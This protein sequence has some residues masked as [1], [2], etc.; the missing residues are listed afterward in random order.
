MAS[1]E[2][3]VL[4]REALVD[5]AVAAPST[6]AL[7]LLYGP[8]PALRFL[9]GLAAALLAQGL[10]LRA[11]RRRIGPERST[12]ADTLTLLRATVGAALAGLVVSGIHDRAGLAGWAAWLAAL[13]AATFCDWLDGP[14]ARRLG[15]TKLGGAL[16]IEADSWL[17]L[18]CAAGA[19]AWGGLPWWVVAPPLA[20]YT[21]PALALARGGLP[22]GGDPW[23]G[24]VTG[25]AQ[26]LLLLTALAPIQ[27]Y[28]RDAALSLAALPIAAGQ[29]ASVLAMIAA[30]L[31]ARDVAG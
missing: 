15:P 13:L 26:V 28:W 16:D 25:V 29:L 10:F 6:L 18:W 9:A 24:V 1:R 20:R 19:V 5:L 2:S 7:G 23:W 3:S 14:S 30:A 21:L 17:T 22:R 31:R 12:P 27:S 11:L 4:R 8:A